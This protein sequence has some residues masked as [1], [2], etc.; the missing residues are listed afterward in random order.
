MIFSRPHLSIWEYA[1]Q[2]AIIVPQINLI[3]YNTATAQSWNMPNKMYNHKQKDLEIIVQ[4]NKTNEE[5]K[6]R[7]LSSSNSSQEILT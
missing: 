1:K 5:I 3:G 2:L 4:K 6:K 7:K